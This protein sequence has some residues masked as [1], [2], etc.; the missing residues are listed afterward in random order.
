MAW[1]DYM[2][3]NE[4]T[5]PRVLI[6]FVGLAYLL[7]AIQVTLSHYRQNFYRK[8]MLVPVLTAPLYC[9][10]A[11]ALALWGRSWL[12]TTFHI[13]MWL[14]VISGL[15]GFYYHFRGVGLRVGGYALRNFLVGP[16][17]IMPLMYSSIAVLGL[18]AVYWR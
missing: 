13:F 11:I 5:L 10:I 14:G 4:W 18:I 7:I 8:V 2:I 16:P 12:F 9:V 6:L 3:W 1:R 17:V 15:I